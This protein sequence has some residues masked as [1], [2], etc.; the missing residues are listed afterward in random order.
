LRVER[1]LL[2]LLPLW[3]PA[4]ADAVL[5]LAPFHGQVVYVDFW[6]SWC[7]PCLE[8][9]PWMNHIQEEFGRNGLVVIAVNVDHEHADAE[10]FLEQHRADFRVVFDP[11]GL[12]PERLGVRVMP[13]SL[14][15]DRTG[16]VR[17]RHE[18]FRLKD[19]D[20]LEQQIRALTL[21]R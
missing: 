8:S 15:V 1:L 7:A 11:Q 6:A 19:R 18:G 20:I 10:R 14:L 13:T 2:C 17:L 4:F 5:D 16:E 3:Q 9:F 12:A 21:A